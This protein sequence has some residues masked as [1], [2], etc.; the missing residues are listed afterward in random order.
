H[1]MRH[2]TLPRAERAARRSVAHP[3]RSFRAAALLA[4][5]ASLV[6]CKKLSE[7]TD[8]P[9][10]DQSGAS[11]AAASGPAA[12]VGPVVKIAAGTLRAGTP[13]GGTPRITTEELVG[14]S[15]SLGEFSIDVL[16]YPNDPS[17]PVR[18]DVSRDE[19]ASLCAQAGKRL[20]TELE[21]ERACK[22]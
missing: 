16:P 17:K 2:P 7:V 11:S 19:A 18:V 4:A 15:I 5:A 13:C 9:A 10:S 3:T 8:K 1:A 12:G 14:D 21:W 22:G 6:A 20:C